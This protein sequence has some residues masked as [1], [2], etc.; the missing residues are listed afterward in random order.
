M[1]IKY[2]SYIGIFIVI[3]IV[4]FIVTDLIP[5]SYS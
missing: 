1:M 3:G 5:V 2:I 4:I